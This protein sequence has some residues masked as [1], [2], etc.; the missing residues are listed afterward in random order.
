MVKFAYLKDIIVM[1][2]GLFAIF[3]FGPVAL[4]LTAFTGYI[5]GN[6]E[7]FR[8]HL[9]SNV[10]SGKLS[11]RIVRAVKVVSVKSGNFYDIHKMTSLTL[12]ILSVLNVVVK[13]R[14]LLKM[15]AKLQR[16][17]TI[18]EAL[19]AFPYKFSLQ[20]VTSKY[21]MKLKPLKHQKTWIFYLISLIF[22][23]VKITISLAINFNI[24]VETKQYVTLIYN[25]LWCV[26]LCSVISQTLPQTFGRL[27]MMQLGNGTVQYMRNLEE[28]E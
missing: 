24:Y 12:L 16:Y 8:K 26:I 9:K 17:F 11:R 5:H 25:I 4:G 10:P 14:K 1:A 28:G 6:S 19:G 23:L 22:H 15:E 18:F 13:F 20:A 3:F 2:A 27:E 7:K 21:S